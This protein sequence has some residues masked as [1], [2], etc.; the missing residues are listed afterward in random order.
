MEPFNQAELASCLPQFLGTADALLLTRP[1][2]ELALR[3]KRVGESDPRVG[4]PKL[5]IKVSEVAG[6]RT[7]LVT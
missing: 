5:S 4:G 3:E 7:T 2:M 1:L 6:R